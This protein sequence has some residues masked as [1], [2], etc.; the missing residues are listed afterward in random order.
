MMHFHCPFWKRESAE[1]T[2]KSPKI[3]AYLPLQVLHRGK[4]RTMLKISSDLKTE[5]THKMFF[6]QRKRASTDQQRACASHVT[7]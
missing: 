4:K 3:G 2:G 7:S 1:K 6:S 5:I